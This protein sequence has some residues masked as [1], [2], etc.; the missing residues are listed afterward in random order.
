MFGDW[1][2]LSHRADLQQEQFA[3]WLAHLERESAKLAVIELGAGEAVPTVRHTSERV[4]RRLNGELI[5]INPREDS[6]PAGH[7]GLRM[8]A[9]EGI[10]H[11]Y[12]R[13]GRV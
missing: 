8:G 2:W 6:V 4:V 13:Y 12:E 7:I 11:I 3:A 1:S 10:D 9:A 5:R